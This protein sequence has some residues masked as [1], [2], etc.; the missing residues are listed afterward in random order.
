[1]RRRVARNFKKEVLL[2][3]IHVKLITSSILHPGARIAKLKERELGYK[4]KK[5]QFEILIYFPQTYGF[6]NPHVHP[7]SFYK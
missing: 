2:K 5:L 4:F 7:P 3:I 6:K 1:L